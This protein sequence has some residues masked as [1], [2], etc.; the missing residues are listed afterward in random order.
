MDCLTCTRASSCRF[1]PMRLFAKLFLAFALLGHTFREEVQ[2][3]SSLLQSEFLST[4]PYKST[5]ISTIT[6]ILTVFFSPPKYRTT[7]SH[8]EARRRQIPIEGTYRTL[9]ATTNPTG[10]NT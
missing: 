7:K 8:I 6:N 10:R 3:V 5:T 1:L 2:R 4:V 9:S